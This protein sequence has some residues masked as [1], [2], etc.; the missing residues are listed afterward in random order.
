MSPGRE[1]LPLKLLRWLLTAGC[2]GFLVMWPFSYGYYTSVGVDLDRRE[3][4]AAIETHARFRWPGNGAFL[5]GADQYWMAEELPLQAFDLGAAFFQAPR[6]LQPQS[7][8]NQWGF[9]HVHWTHPPRELPVRVS[10]RASAGW[11]GVPAWLPILV[12]GFWPLRTWLR[13]RRGLSAR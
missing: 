13:G 8:W 10:H 12:T 9:W 3:E 11:L 6:P 7:T 4:Q 5:V 2:L 1:P